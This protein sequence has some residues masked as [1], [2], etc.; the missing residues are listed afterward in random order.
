[1][2]E[3]AQE[4]SRCLRAHV[5]AEKDILLL[6]SNAL[7]LLQAQ[8]SFQVT[9]AV[10]L[11]FPAFGALFPSPSVCLH[12]ANLN[13]LPRTDLWSLRLRAQA[14]PSISGCDVHCW[15]Y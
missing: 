3:A 11:H 5:C 1:M 12:I 7:L 6:S 13:S 4:V 9:L 8:A 14:L 10:A 15:W 2:C